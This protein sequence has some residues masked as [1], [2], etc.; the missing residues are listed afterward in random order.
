[1]RRTGCSLPWKVKLCC[2][3]LQ[4]NSCWHH[5][6]NGM[7]RCLLSSFVLVDIIS[8]LENIISK[9]MKAC[10][11]EL[12]AYQ[13]H[14]SYPNSAAMVLKQI[15]C[16]CMDSVQII[17]ILFFFQLWAFAQWF[18]PVRLQEPGTTYNLSKLTQAGRA[19]PKTW[20]KQSFT[21]WRRL[22]F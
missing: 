17:Q 18:A 13:C 5:Y 2:A 6:P 8:S 12:T 15:L 22:L 9:D 7:I 16:H 21:A 19:K 20:D 3:W 11:I 10:D 1:M 14:C 4:K